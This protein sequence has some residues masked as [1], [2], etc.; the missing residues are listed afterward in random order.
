MS[1]L[2]KNMILLDTIYHDKDRTVVYI[3]IGTGTLYARH[4]ESNSFKMVMNRGYERL[5]ADEYLIGEVRSSG[6]SAHFHSK[7]EK[8]EHLY[9]SEEILKNQTNTSNTMVDFFVWF[10][11]HKLGVLP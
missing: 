3:E 6:K 9:V 2:K 8:H 7:T 11:K 4:K 5:Y 10:V 1:M